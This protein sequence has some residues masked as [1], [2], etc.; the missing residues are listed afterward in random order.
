MCSQYSWLV[1][2]QLTTVGSNKVVL[3]PRLNWSGMSNWVYRFA[4]SI[5]FSFFSPF[6]SFLSRSSF[7]EQTLDPYSLFLYSSHQIELGSQGQLWSSLTDSPI[8]S[9]TS[10]RFSPLSFT[11]LHPS[12]FRISRLREIASLTPYQTEK[13]HWSQTSAD[14]STPESLRF[15]FTF[16]THI[17]F[18][19]FS[20]VF[21][22]NFS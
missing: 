11:Y 18:P 8:V 9:L 6:P 22:E 10:P 17:N 2:P 16:Q 7:S 1:R 21:S 3:T 15:S 5:F 14:E 13:H 12:P 20:F 19:S 4:F